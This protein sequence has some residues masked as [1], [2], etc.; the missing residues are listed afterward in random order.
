MK[1]T[2]ARNFNRTKRKKEWK[3]IILPM[4]WTTYEH[5]CYCISLEI[6]NT[7]GILLIH[8]TLRGRCPALL[9]C[10]LRFEIRLSALLLTN[11]FIRS[12]F[13][14]S[15]VS[16]I[17]CRW[18]IPGHNI[19]KLYYI[20]ANIGLTT[21]ERDLSQITLTCSKSTMETLEKGVKYVQSWL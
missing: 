2:N 1:S 13:S 20:L 19:L 6:L 8:G 10:Y 12:I 15:Q 9:C 4:N 11:F 3:L 18:N 14:I 5:G 17:H 21:I 7:E 16:K